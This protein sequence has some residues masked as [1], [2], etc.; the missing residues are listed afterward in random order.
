MFPGQGSQKKGMGEDIFSAYPV[1]TRQASE[2]LGYD[3]ERLC[4]QDSQ[5]QL[6]QTEYTQPA[7]YVVSS[8]L[9]LRAV[10]EQG[11]PK[12][13]VGHSLGEYTALFAANCFDFLTGLSLVAER[14]KLM[15]A[16]A[17][18]G[19]LAVIGLTVEAIKKILSDHQF[20][21]IDIANHNTMEYVVVS[22]AKENIVRVERLLARKARVCIPLEVSGAFHSRQMRNARDQFEKSI[23]KYQFR[24]PEIP[25]IANLTARPYHCQD[26]V[27]NLVNQI[28]G[29]VCWVDSIRYLMRL[30]ESEFK[31]IGPGKVL[32]GMIRRIQ[33]EVT[34]FPLGKL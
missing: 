1:L 8:L 22:G 5:Q 13:V 3:V 31:Q 12:Y 7:L 28:T 20:D 19:M 15:G 14:G 21:S 26:I 17:G 6:I 32:S 23:K 25:I 30:G 4:L 27:H 10:E 11:S 18:G 2:L 34:C 24:A 9:Y 29:T 33:Q 16:V